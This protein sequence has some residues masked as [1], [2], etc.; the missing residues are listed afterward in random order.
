M[1]FDQ[2]KCNP[3]CFFLLL[4]TFIIHFT[5]QCLAMITSYIIQTYLFSPSLLLTSCLGNIQW[6]WAPTALVSCCNS[7]FLNASCLSR[8]PLRRLSLVFLSLRIES[9]VNILEAWDRVHFWARSRVSGRW[10]ACLFRFQIRFVKVVGDRI[11]SCALRDYLPKKLTNNHTKPP[12][13]GN[14][15]G[16]W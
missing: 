7:R 16:C 6:R 10:R 9:L 15:P 4:K 2:K 13:L 3:G 1:K 12:W 14:N 8:P 11:R 5:F